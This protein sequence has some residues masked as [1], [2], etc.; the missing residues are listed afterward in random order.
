MTNPFVVAGEDTSRDFPLDPLVHEASWFIDDIGDHGTRL[1]EFVAAIGDGSALQRRG[2][3]VVIEGPERS[4]KTTL[5]NRCVHVVR[6]RFPATGPTQLYTL[7]LRSVTQTGPSGTLRSGPELRWATCRYALGKATWMTAP[8][9]AEANGFLTDPDSNTCDPGLAYLIMQNT[10]GSDQVAQVLLPIGPPEIESDNL[11]TY[12]HWMGP[13]MIFFTERTTT[14]SSREL[15]IRGD[16]QGDADPVLALPLRHLLPG[17][18]WTIVRRRIQTL[19]SGN[20][21][22]SVDPATLTK[23]E[24]LSRTD[25]NTVGWVVAL[26]RQLYLRRI[27]GESDFAGVPSITFE[28]ITDLLARFGYE[29]RL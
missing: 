12:G 25:Q 19:S 1:A 29:G 22:P 14:P 5:L 15:N 7:D 3:L 20:T 27:S 8:E 16:R 11:E 17:E 13:R 9:R 6:D 23:V 18:A 26:F 2:R 21:L 4:G 10:L 24:G 28:E